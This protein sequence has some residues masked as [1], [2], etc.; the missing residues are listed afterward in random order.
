MLSNIFAKKFLRSELGNREMTNIIVKH[1]AW[2]ALIRSQHA[3]QMWMSI[4]W[5]GINL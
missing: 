5:I 2:R 4:T 3:Q 1:D